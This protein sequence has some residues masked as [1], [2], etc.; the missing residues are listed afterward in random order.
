MDLEIF[1]P[2][3]AVAGGIEDVTSFNGLGTKYKVFTEQKKSHSIGFESGRYA[4]DGLDLD[5]GIASYA[6]RRAG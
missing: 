6:L 3:V 4:W 2:I 1:A 5:V